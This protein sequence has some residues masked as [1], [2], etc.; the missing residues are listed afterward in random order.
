MPG[1]EIIKEIEQSNLKTDDIPS[2]RAGD[3]VR[4]HAKVIEGGKERIQV[5]EGVVI[6]KQ[7]ELNRES[8]IV[9][10]ISHGVGVER[11]FLLHS[12]RVTRIEVTR[13][14]KVRRA[15][16]YYLRDRVGKAA[17]LKELRD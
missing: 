5:F 13:R 6:S 16:L 7:N 2:F 4:V 3:T 17:R 14:A 9:R 15:K 1:T 8:F 12:P 11:G 10:K